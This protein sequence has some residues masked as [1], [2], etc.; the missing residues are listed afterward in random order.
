[1]EVIARLVQ[2][3]VPGLLGTA[4]AIKVNAFDNG[5]SPTALTETTLN[6]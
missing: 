3:G 5:L 6:E 4:A 2:Y 1:M